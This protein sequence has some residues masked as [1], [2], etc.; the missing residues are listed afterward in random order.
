M[1]LYIQCLIILLVWCMFCTILSRSDSFYRHIVNSD[2][3]Q[4]F[5]IHGE[6]SA[7]KIKSPTLIQRI[8]DLSL[9]QAQAYDLQKAVQYDQGSFPTVASW[10]DEDPRLLPRT[11]G[12]KRKEKETLDERRMRIK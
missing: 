11:E 12:R 7:I 4:E 2:Q 5:M 6:G 3:H 1:H 9:S 8:D 10:Q